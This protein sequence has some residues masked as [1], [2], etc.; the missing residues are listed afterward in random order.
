M[1]VPHYQKS[2]VAS[3]FDY[4]EIRNVMVSLM[5]ASASHN[6]S[7]SANTGGSQLSNTAVKPDSCLMQIFCQKNF[8]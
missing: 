6:V 4:I 7:A 1:L 8:V 3:H 2:Q 5:M